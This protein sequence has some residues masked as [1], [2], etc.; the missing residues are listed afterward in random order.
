MK[1]LRLIIL[2]TFVLG[3]RIAL[4]GNPERAGQ[5]GATQLLINPY[6]R[7]GG[8]NGINTANAYGIE[9]TFNNPAGI[10]RTKKT[11]LVFAH[12]RYL[13]GTDIN[14][15]TFGLSQSLKKGGVIGLT[16]TAFDMGDFV[17]TTIDQ[18]DGTL[19]TFSPT[20]MNIGLSYAKTFVEDRI[21]VGFTVRMIHESIS[22]VAANGVSFDAGVQYVDKKDRIRIGVCLKNVGPDMKFAGDGLA[23]RANLG[24]SNSG[25]TS[26]VSTTA[27]KFQLPS[28]LNIGAAYE[29]KIGATDS[30]EATHKVIPMINF[31]AN[32]FGNDRMGA[33][34]EYRFKEKV[35]FP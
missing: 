4:A 28:L 5:A 18:P 21:F 35:S 17:R 32:A 25:Y 3:G 20:I 31:A 16:A 23:T 10:A 6:A 15:N 19:G 9:A 8:F 12:T 29:I 22:D 7:S 24:G 14:I 1:T 26:S 30:T 13:V 33:G 27:A 11:E 34:V 2:L